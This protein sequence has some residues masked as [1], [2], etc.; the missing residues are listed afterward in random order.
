MFATSYGIASGAVQQLPQIL[1]GHAQ[2]VAEGQAAV[3]QVAEASDA[4]L[5]EGRRK[6]ITANSRDET[7]AKI[8]IW[9]EI[10]G[11]VGRFLLAALTV[12][13]VRRRT[14]LRI[15]QLPDLIFVPLLFWWIS[16]SLGNA[17]SLVNIKTGIFIAALLTVA[18]FSFWGNY[19]PRVFPLHLHGTGESFAA[20]I[21][22][23]IIGTAAAW[24][25]LT[26]W[27]ATPPDPG[28]IALVGAVVAGLYCL[29]GAALSFIMIE[30][31]SETLDE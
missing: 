31:E 22:G 2:I 3:E 29:V 17:E 28:K 7:V 16:T 11:L 10:G 4:P 26:F 25:T 14:R 5:S 18:Q 21:S 20:N 23:R 9:Q 30:P 12:R 15:F 27:A 13:I 24:L 19:I 6:Q 8:T 1:S